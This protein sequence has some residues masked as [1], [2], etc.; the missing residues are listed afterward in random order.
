MSF[1]YFERTQHGTPYVLFTWSFAAFS[2]GL[3]LSQLA[4][5]EQYIF[6][7]L[8]KHALNGSILLLLLMVCLFLRYQANSSKVI[9]S[10]DA[11]NFC[12]VMVF[13]RE[14]AMMVMMGAAILITIHQLADKLFKQQ[15]K[16]LWYVN[17]GEVLFQSGLLAFVALT[18][19][20]VRSFLLSNS[21]ATLQDLGL[22]ELLASFVIYTAI[23]TIRWS[24]S[25][26]QS[27]MQGIS[28]VEYTRD[29]KQ[30]SALPLLLT[31]ISTVLLAF[32]MVIVLNLSL[33][34]FLILAGVFVSIVTL[35]N[36]QAKT[37]ESLQSTIVEL[38]ILNGV[39]RSLGNASQTR[40]QLF[41]SLYCQGRDL[42]GADSF[43]LYLYPEN[44][45]AELSLY[46]TEEQLVESKK[47]KGERNLDPIDGKLPEEQA[48]GFAKWCANNRRT[49]RVDNVAHQANYYVDT[50]LTDC[51]PYKSW[52]G[53]PLEC[54]QNLLGVISVASLAKRAFTEQ[55]EEILRVLSHQVVSAVENARLYEMATVDALTG[56]VSARHLRQR[57]GEE[58]DSAKRNRKPLSVV[59]IDIDYF[60][61]IN[62]SHGHEVGNEVLKHLAQILRSSI[63]DGDIAARYGGEEFTILL[64]ATSLDIASKV[65]ERLR[66]AVQR[67]PANT[68]VG[69]L[70]ITA[71]FGVACYPQTD[72]QDQSQLLSAAD[73]ALYRSKQKG[74]NCVSQAEN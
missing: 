46:K 68:S 10:D 67:S 55:H 32:S 62:D 29:I 57:L 65:A 70:F 56:L 25:F 35:L 47:K 6:L 49:L 7:L 61:K 60:K 64:P 11:I 28:I 22:K 21:S 33:P 73:T 41:S 18:G 9:S 63:R 42:F 43:A 14:V 5:S 3:I 44:S 74:R 34:L 4:G 71:S 58:F 38:K 66:T 24:I 1:S 69:E 53:V 72:F 16:H 8:K 13:E 19:S 26:V 17:V 12:I 54:E 45:A 27:W 51:I 37:R 50:L 30:L 31:E 20:T 2:W 36:H 15:W 39:G 59:M 52:L 48:I 40:R 23:L